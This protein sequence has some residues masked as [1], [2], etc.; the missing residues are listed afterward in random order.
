MDKKLKI[1]VIG[2]GNISGVHL[3]AYSLN[4]N[5]EIY[6][7]CDINEKAMQRRAKEYGVT[8]LFT[9]VNEM[10]KLPELDAVSVCT[11]NAAH[12][13]CAIAALNAGKHVLCEKPMATNVDEARHE[14]SRRKER[15]APHDRLR[16]PLR[17]RLRHFEGLH[18]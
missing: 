16:A 18:R 4:P 12:A 15:Q 7:L 11:W 2:N 14:G 17:Q 8:R 9:D 6:A 10:V 3:R 5:V 13:E 1:G